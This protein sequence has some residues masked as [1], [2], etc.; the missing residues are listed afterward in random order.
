VPTAKPPL[1]AERLKRLEA[2]IERL[3]GNVVGLSTSLAIIG[4]LNERQFMLEKRATL[5]EERAEQIAKV[6]V[7]K[8]FLGKELVTLQ[9]AN[10]RRLTG[11]M[12]MLFVLLVLIGYTR[13]E[14]VHQI[15]DRLVGSN[16]VCI[17]TDKHID[18]ELKLLTSG[19]QPPPPVIQ[20]TIHDLALLRRDCNKLFGPQTRPSFF[21][22]IL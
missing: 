18:I 22:G 12:A 9:V 11:V 19:K 1:D 4:E 14:S 20:K 7:N 15:D 2:A 10:R 17:S 16:E 8:E 5:T 13:Y 21:Q 3:S 6:A